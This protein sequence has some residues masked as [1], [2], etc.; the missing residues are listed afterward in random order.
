MYT[1]EEQFFLQFGGED[2]ARLEIEMFDFKPAKPY[3]PF[4]SK[5]QIA[6]IQKSREV[7]VRDKPADYNEKG[8]YKWGGD[9]WEINRVT[10]PS[11][12][13]RVKFYIGW[14]DDGMGAQRKF[15]MWAEDVRAIK[16]AG[17]NIS[18][19]AGLNARPGD[20]SVSITVIDDYEVA[21]YTEGHIGIVMPPEKSIVD[22][23]KYS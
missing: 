9:M 6:A 7:V 13:G 19:W 23:V 14:A 17:Y 20:H 15:I 3:S 16:E 22:S 10:T 5:P 12:Y 2:Y 8:K 21:E 18:E 11:I 4:G 1:R